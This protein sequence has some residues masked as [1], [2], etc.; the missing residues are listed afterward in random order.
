M[1]IKRWWKDKTSKPQIGR[2]N[3]FNMTTETTSRCKKFNCPQHTYNIRFNNIEKSFGDA[4]F[5]I[6]R[7]F[8]DLHEK[9]K[10]IAHMQ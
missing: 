8:T 1:S 4:Q 9:F 5:E 7:L 3:L 10:I 2:S 6:Q